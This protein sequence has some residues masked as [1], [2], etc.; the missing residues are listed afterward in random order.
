MTTADIIH[1]RL[2]N[3][4]LTGSVFTKPGEIVSWLVAMQS[5]EFAMA[6][7]AIGLRVPGLT[8]AAIEKAFNDGAIL[9]THLIQPTW[10]FEVLGF[11]C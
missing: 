11:R 4:Q 8:D 1:Y 6:K 5:Q 7:W 2:V 9:R 10:K 3:Q